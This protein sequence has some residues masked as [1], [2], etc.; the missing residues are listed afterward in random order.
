MRKRTWLIALVVAGCFTIG[1][2][3]PSAQKAGVGGP[4]RP[5]VTR[6]AVPVAGDP[7]PGPGYGGGGRF[8][9]S[10]AR[11][12]GVTTQKFPIGAGALAASRACNAEHPV[13]RLCEWAEIFRAIPPIALES[14]VLV[15][16]NY[17]T[18]PVPV[19]L[20]TNGG[21]NCRPMLQRL[22]AACCGYPV[23]TS[24][25]L[26]ALV[27]SP[28]GSATVNSCSDVLGFTATALDAQGMPLAGIQVM[29]EFRPVVGGTQNLIGNFNP[30]FAV[31]DV[32]G[33]AATTLTINSAI[34]EANCT[35]G[36]H[37]CSALI[38]VRDAAGLIVSVAVE[39]LDNIP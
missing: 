35:G 5:M 14:E 32:E 19:C 1:L 24:G 36:G 37:D 28:D 8:I 16:P 7:I 30:A 21:L 12:V 25:P 23:P 39:L 20:N 22:P 17:E 31:T 18:D 10:P 15:A 4:P 26:A 34:C 13:S 2:S 38:E 29:F 33:N 9:G 6:A 11:F 3:A 27:L